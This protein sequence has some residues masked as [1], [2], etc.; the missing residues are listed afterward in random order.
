MVPRGA[1]GGWQGV[2]N[3]NYA[4]TSSKLPLAV[5]AHEHK[6]VTHQKPSIKMLNALLFSSKPSILHAGW[7]IPK[8]ATLGNHKTKKSLLVL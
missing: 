7:F 1:L 4:K 3:T 8:P 5:A 6:T 2:P